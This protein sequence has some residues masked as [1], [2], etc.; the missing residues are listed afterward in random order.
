MDGPWVDPTVPR[1]CNVS[2]DRAGPWPSCEAIARA[3]ALRNRRSEGLEES[4]VPLAR[5]Y[6]NYWTP[7]TNDGLCS[8][9]DTQ[10]W[11]GGDDCLQATAYT[12]WL[13]AGTVLLLIV[14]GFAAGYSVSWAVRRR[15]WKKREA[16]S[17]GAE[18]PAWLRGAI[19]LGWSLADWNVGLCLVGLLIMLLTLV[20]KGVAIFTRDAATVYMFGILRA[21]LI[22]L[23]CSSLFLLSIAWSRAGLAASSHATRRPGLARA[24]RRPAGLYVFSALLGLILLASIALLILSQYLLDFKYLRYAYSLHVCTYTLFVLL[25][26]DCSVDVYQATKMGGLAGDTAWERVRRGARDSLQIIFRCN[27]Y[28]AQEERALLIAED[29]E[30]SSGTTHGPAFVLRI[31]RD[32]VR[33]CS[34]VVLCVCVDLFGV[35]LRIVAGDF[36]QR[37]F[38][39]APALAVV[40][41]FTQVGIIA[42]LTLTVQYYYIAARPPRRRPALQQNGLV[43]PSGLLRS[44]IYEAT[45][46][47]GEAPTG[48]EA[49]GDAPA[50][51]APQACAG[52]GKAVSHATVLDSASSQDADTV[53]E[54]TQ[55]QESGI[56]L[57]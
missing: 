8:C 38:H 19:C 11:L 13:G 57:A 37:Q 12:Y 6:A 22:F 34:S 20:A 18:P 35:L 23:V 21:L 40:V 50:G 7:V 2:N 44:T 54:P 30:A 33:V 4:D 52:P 36:A 29:F 15:R 32:L 55:L 25:L 10:T 39:E 47:G 42:C 9:F 17:A 31:R 24:M 5:C 51:E 27:L 43:G 46:P 56:C 16:R 28:S 14:I 48:Y 1:D 53:E 3:N 45:Q 41:N 26:L 49:G